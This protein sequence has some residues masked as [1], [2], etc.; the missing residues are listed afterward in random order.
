MSRSSLG[1]SLLA[2]LV[3][4]P[5]PLLAQR[6]KDVARTLAT[7]R[8]KNPALADRISQAHGYAVFPT[9]G[10]GG[11]GIGGAHGK[12]L[13]YAGGKRIGRVSLTQVT[14]GFQLGGQAFSEVILFKDATALNDFIKGQF[15]LDAQVSAIAVTAR[16]GA[17]LPYRKGVAVLTM[18]KGGLMYEASVGGQKFVYTADGQ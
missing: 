1:L 6:D 13:V 8:E 10:K 16:A 7:I 14:V 18:G 5:A 3:A 4:M 2:A 17:D 11:I 12:G 15:E 9:V